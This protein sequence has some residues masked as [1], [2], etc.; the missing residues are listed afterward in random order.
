M[1]MNVLRYTA[2][3]L[4]ALILLSAAVQAKP[5]DN[6]EYAEEPV[7]NEEFLEQ[8]LSAVDNSAQGR[9]SMFVWSNYL[10]NSGAFPALSGLLTDYGIDRVYQDIPEAYFQSWELRELVGNLSK[11]GIETVA[12][13]GDSSWTEEGLGE[14]KAWIDNLYK[15]NR[16]F[17]DRA[18]PAVALDVESHTLSTYKKDP[19]AGF[20]AYSKSM[21]EAYQYARQRGFRVIQIIPTSLDTVDREQFE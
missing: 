3:L 15:Y 8:G 19:A 1:K 11:R 6:W 20:A 7:S 18:I 4:G 14:Y 9:R 21:E 10:F 16:S 13:G 5:A 12:L 17:P 2:G